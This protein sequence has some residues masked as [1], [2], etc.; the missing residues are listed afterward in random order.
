MI[1]AVVVPLQELERIRIDGT[2]G[3]AACAEGPEPFAADAL[4]QAL[5]DDA[6]SGIPGAQEQHVVLVS[7]SSFVVVHSDSPHD[8][9]PARVTAR[10]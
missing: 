9:R 5:G 7:A 3:E 4:E 2:G 6:A 8:D 1:G 10:R